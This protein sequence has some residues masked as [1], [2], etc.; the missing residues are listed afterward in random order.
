MLEKEFAVRRMS[1]HLQN[2][3]SIFAKQHDLSMVTRGIEVQRGRR[4]RDRRTMREKE[5][6]GDAW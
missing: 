4:S 6:S 2:I 3:A 5:G 1:S